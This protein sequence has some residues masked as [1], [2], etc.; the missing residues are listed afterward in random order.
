MLHSVG[1][2][3]KREGSFWIH[4]FG[5]PSGRV[6]KEVAEDATVNG[7]PSGKATVKQL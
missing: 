3:P 6:A 2:D 7:E 5:E 4:Y 1:V